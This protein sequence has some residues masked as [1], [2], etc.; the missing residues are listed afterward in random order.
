M[1]CSDAGEELVVTTIAVRR[2]IAIAVVDGV[3]AGTSV[4]H[5]VPVFAKDRVVSCT[6]VQYV[7]AGSCPF[8]LRVQINNINDIIG[9]RSVDR[10]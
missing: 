1:V 9:V 7:V 5:I 3:V 6:A 8:T 2:I 10:T 4:D